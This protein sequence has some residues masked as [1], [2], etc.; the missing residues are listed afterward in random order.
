MLKRG[1]GI[2]FAFIGVVVGAGFAS[3]MEAFQYFVSYGHMGLWGIALAGVV[4]AFAAVAFLAFGSY[5]RATEHTRVFGA[6]SDGLSSRIMDWSAIACMF[7]VGF[8]M[9]AGAGSNLEQ[10]YGLSLIHI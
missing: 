1:I 8:V 4:M 5:F 6:V 3:G 2:G 7:S 10:A 9:F